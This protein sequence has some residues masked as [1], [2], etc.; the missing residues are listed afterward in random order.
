MSWPLNCPKPKRQSRQ[1]DLQSLST[2][3]LPLPCSSFIPPAHPRNQ[4]SPQRRVGSA[5][6]HNKRVL[7]PSPPLETLRIP[8]REHH[9]QINTPIATQP[10]DRDACTIAAKDH[11]NYKPL[12]L[13]LRRLSG[14]ILI[15]CRQATVNINSQSRP[16]C[17]AQSTSI[18]ITSVI[19]HRSSR[20]V[21]AWLP[22]PALLR[23]PRV[24]DINPASGNCSADSCL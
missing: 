5:G 8:A 14:C 18:P 17:L 22:P 21:V 6:Q 11:D 4:V 12:S 9:T 19:V 7:V 3:T 23:L 1:P 10:V 15:S 16:A 20:K 13:T 24:S 2:H